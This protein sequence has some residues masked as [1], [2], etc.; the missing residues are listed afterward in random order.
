MGI[1]LLRIVLGL[2]CVGC[3]APRQ[4]TSELNEALAWF[5]PP[6]Q[7]SM[8]LQ[9][10]RGAP[11]EPTRPIQPPASVVVAWVPSRSSADEEPTRISTASR[12]AWTA[13]IRGK[14]ERSGLGLTVAV[15]PPDAFEHGVS[16]EGVQTVAQQHTA[17]VVVLFGVDVSRR[18]YNVFEPATPQTGVA[19]V[20]PPQPPLTGV[21]GVTNII[22]VVSTAR[23][24]GVTPAGKP[25]FSASK[26]G[27]D[28]GADQYVSVFDLE[29]VSSRAAVDELANSIVRHLEQLTA[30]PST[31][32]AR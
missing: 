21:K 26:R 6:E 22:E 14:L 12:E 19:R 24:I 27:Y 9:S 20:T 32:E 28:V 5:V 1:W 10:V 30:T 2:C 15:T 23:V 8:W 3:F 13:L 16:L 17:R 29:E 11:V 7:S 18:R 31:G 25:L 4:T